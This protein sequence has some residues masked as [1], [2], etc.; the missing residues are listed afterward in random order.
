[1]PDK[2]ISLTKQ[3][4]RESRYLPRTSPLKS[5]PGHT[6]TSWQTEIQQIK[7]PL[8]T[9]QR[10]TAYTSSCVYVPKIDQCVWHDDDKPSIRAIWLR[11]WSVRVAFSCT[12]CAAASHG[13]SS[14]E[15]WQDNEVDGAGGLQVRTTGEQVTNK[16]P[17]TCILKAVS[18]EKKENY[19]APWLNRINLPI[20][21]DRGVEGSNPS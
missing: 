5:Y 1:M 10:D 9:T 16:I 2:L 21:D 19:C 8:N 15:A 13:K 18:F 11:L 20:T 6:R 14:G 3:K 17:Y 12:S 4:K 7:S